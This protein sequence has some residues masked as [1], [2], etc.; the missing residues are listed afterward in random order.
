M[1]VC[2]LNKANTPRKAGFAE[3]GQLVKNFVLFTFPARGER[4]NENDKKRL[5][6]GY[7]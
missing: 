3:C 2:S 5:S 6:Y 4:G 1:V 7:I